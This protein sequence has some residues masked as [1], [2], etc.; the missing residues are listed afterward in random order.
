[1]GTLLIVLVKRVQVIKFTPVDFMMTWKNRLG[2]AYFILSLEIICSNV[3]VKLYFRSWKF[4]VKTKIMCEGF[5]PLTRSLTIFLC[6]PALFLGELSVI[7]FPHSA[8]GPVF[9]LMVF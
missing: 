6:V 2:Q 8:L 1:M 3:K 7:S 9:L 5:K 4:I